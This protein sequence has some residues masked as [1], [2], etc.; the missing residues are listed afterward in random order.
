MKCWKIVLAVTPSLLLAPPPLSAELLERVVAKVNGDIVT[1]TEFTQRQV[2]AAQAAHVSPDGVASFLQQ[3]NA[4]ILQEAIDDLLIVQ[5]ADELGIQLRPEVLDGFI[6][7]IKNENH[8]QSEEELLAQLREE[9]MTLNDL[10]RSIERSVL[11]RQVLMA[12]L[13]S[14]TK[15]TDEELVAAY[16]ERRATEFSRPAT[17]KLQEMVLHGDNAR[18]EAEALVGRLRAGEDFAALAQL[19]STAPSRA[20]GGDLGT[21][22]IGEMS[23]SHQQT[24]S[25]LQPGEVSDPIPTGDGAY[26]ILRVVEKNPASVAPY[27]EVKENLRARLTRERMDKEY[28]A[29]IERLRKP[30][31]IEV[32]IREAQTQIAVPDAPTAA[33]AATSL[34]VPVPGLEDELSVSG[35]QEPVKTAPA[36]PEKP[37]GPE[38]EPRSDPEAPN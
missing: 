13:E 21:I 16:E 26:Q 10:R 33:T 2:S 15:V 1:Y 12:D 23:A 37:E 22:A 38:A 7:D 3:N 14:K 30:A 35:D 27:E 19:Y 29:Y 8:I 9:G 36:A 18:Q 24:I 28:A 31:I 11:R 20:S 25:A 34:P 17:V 4:R 6:E 5:R 32:K